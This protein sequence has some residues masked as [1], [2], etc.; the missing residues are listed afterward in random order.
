MTRLIL[1][2]SVV[3]CL[4]EVWE[5]QFSPFPLRVP[6]LPRLPRLPRECRAAW[7]ATFKNIDWPS[8]KGL[9]PEAQQAELRRIIDRAQQLGINALIFQVRPAC[10][11]LYKSRYEP[12]SEYLTGTIAKSPGSD[13]LQLAIDLAQQR[14]IEL[15]VWFN[16]YRARHYE[17][18][19]AAS[20][21]ITFKQPHLVINYSSYQWLDPSRKEARDLAINVMV[22]VTKRYDVDGIHMDD[23]FYPYQVKDNKGRKID[24]ADNESYTAYQRQGGRLD[25]RV[26]RRTHVDALV[27]ELYQAVKAIKP[28]VKFGIS[29]FGIWRPGVPRGIE[30]ELDA[31][32]E[33]AAD[34]RKWMQQ[35]WVDY[36]SPQLYW[37]IQPWAQSYSALLDCWAAQ[38]RGGRHVWPGIAVARIGQNR[39]ANEILNQISLARRDKRVSGQVFWNLKATLSN[40][41]GIADILKRGMYASPALVPGSPWL[42]GYRVAAPE[43]TFRRI[44][45]GG[46]PEFTWRRGPNEVRFWVAQYLANGK[47]HNTNLPGTTTSWTGPANT[48]GVAFSTFTRTGYLSTPYTFI[49]P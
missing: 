9:S 24:F 28:W 19:R 49:K 10:D 43:I 18:S 44:Q 12:S 38:S 20:N 23:Y 16:P 32:E 35:G 21:H 47:W 13:P 8:R 30:A 36:T 7:V 31:Y 2:L 29:P 6:R 39:D 11:A 14:G 40:K 5:Q 25:R 15:H 46:K 27:Y 41:G 42:G 37:T 34:A 22:D 26:W 4:T 48:T 45:Q 33:L 3:A 1:A 17:K